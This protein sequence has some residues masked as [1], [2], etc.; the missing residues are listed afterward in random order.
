MFISYRNLGTFIILK[1]FL[2]TSNVATP[3]TISKLLEPFYFEFKNTDILLDITGLQ[4]LSS[5]IPI[6]PNKMMFRVGDDNYP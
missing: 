5:Y 1:V 4:I 3:K 2:L 6:L